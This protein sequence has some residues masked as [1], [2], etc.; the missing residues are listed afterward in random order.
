MGRRRTIAIVVV[1][2]TVAMLG[3][4]VASKGVTYRA[5]A[6]FSRPPIP[7]PPTESPV[8]GE[9]PDVVGLTLDEAKAVLARVG[10]S[11]VAV[12]EIEANG[13]Q[14]VQATEPDAH[15]AVSPTEVVVVFV[16]R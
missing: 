16:G 14:T 15:Y 6:V 10:Y 8:P 5:E 12:R 1:L 3:V 2:G 7:R 13:D 4:L 9:V 11:R